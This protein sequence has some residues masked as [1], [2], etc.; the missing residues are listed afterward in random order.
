ML[1]KHNVINSTLN[2]MEKLINICCFLII[3]SAVYAQNFE[4]KNY[5]FDDSNLEVPA[6]LI[7]ENEVILQR[8]IKKE[9][10]V[11]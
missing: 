2:P 11:D 7:N 5:N 6:S 10:T 4:F 8:T 3:T 9:V 1:L